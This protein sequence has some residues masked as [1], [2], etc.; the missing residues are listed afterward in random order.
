M[1]ARR[2]SECFGA[3]EGG[4]VACALPV[5]AM[6]SMALAVSLLCG[7]L[8]ICYQLLRTRVAAKRL[9][10]DIERFCDV[11]SRRARG[12]ASVARPAW[13]PASRD[14]ISSMSTECN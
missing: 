8:N 9:A 7:A 5:D 2:Q 13:A 12:G 1:N 10:K 11:M 4:R 3:A 14:E 6:C